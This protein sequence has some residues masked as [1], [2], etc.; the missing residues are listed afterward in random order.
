ME[1]ALLRL[2]RPETS[3]DPASLGARLDRL[4]DR[5]RRLGEAPPPPV[6]VAPETRRAARMPEPEAPAAPAAVSSGASEPPGAEAKPR[7]VTKKA[8]AEG[9]GEPPAAPAAPPAAPGPPPADLD[10]AAVEAIWPALVE[11]VRKDAGPRRHALFRACRPAGVQGERVVLEVP[12]NLPFHLAQLAEDREL[13][14]IVGRIAG[15][16]LGGTVRVVYRAGD[17]EEPGGTLGMDPLRAPDK[18][19]LREGE[20]GAADPTAVVTEVFGGE[21][22]STPPKPKKP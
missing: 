1:L 5:M 2:A 21:V 12:A 14:G 17:G 19:L 15:S 20:D 18:D 6:V 22:V 10:L 3:I 13:D 16:L 9:P 8:A 4:E 11:R 7:R